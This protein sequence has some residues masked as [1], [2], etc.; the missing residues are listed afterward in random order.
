[1]GDTTS[2]H[3][4]SQFSSRGP[5]LGRIAANRRDALKCTG[6]KNSS[7][8]RRTALNAHRLGTQTSETASARPIQTKTILISEM[9]EI[10]TNPNQSFQ[11]LGYQELSLKLVPVLGNPVLQ[12]L[13]HQDWDGEGH[14]SQSGGM[15]GLGR[16]ELPTHGLG[17]RCSIHLSYRPVSSGTP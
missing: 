14:P 7:G 12:D 4:F 2:A 17:N 3:E 11:V 16:F 13:S 5:S 6:Q 15:V 1:V 8:K 9:A 10:F